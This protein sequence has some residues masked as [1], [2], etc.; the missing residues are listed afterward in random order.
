MSGV[1][2]GSSFILLHVTIQ[3]TLFIEE[4]VI[5]PTSLLGSLVKYELTV[6]AWVY[7]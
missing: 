5:S 7:F 6:D 1:R 3:L 2:H 4:T